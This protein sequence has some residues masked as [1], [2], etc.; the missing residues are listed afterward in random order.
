M[1][2]REDLYQLEFYGP[3]YSHLSTKGDGSWERQSLVRQFEG[4]ISRARNSF[5]E[6]M[7]EMAALLQ[8]V[9]PQFRDLLEEYRTNG[10]LIRF[11]MEERELLQ[12]V[13]GQNALEDLFQSLYG[14]EQTKPYWL[15]GESYFQSGFYERAA[16]AFSRALE[17]S[18]ADENLRFIHHLSQG[19]I[20]FYSFA[21]QQALK[22]LE[23]CISIAAPKEVVENYRDMIFMVCQKIQEEF[24]GRRKGDQHRD[25]TKKAKALQRQV[26]KLCLLP[27]TPRPLPPKK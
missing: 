13:L 21:P 5:R 12:D 22:S 1:K 7:E 11:F 3:T 20:Q 16:Q 18:P 9:L 17:K 14:L 26:E 24:P 23:N 2:M 8:D 10:L 25:L 4:L 27:P 15:A 6:A 19:M